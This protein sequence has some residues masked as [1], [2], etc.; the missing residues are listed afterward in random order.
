MWRSP[1][2]DIACFGTV[3]RYDVQNPHCI[4]STLIIPILFNK[5]KRAQNRHNNAHQF[6]LRKTSV[7][8]R[9]MKHLQFQ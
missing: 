6:G 3:R 9:L 2:R 1:M 5:V 7:K 4:D 8:I